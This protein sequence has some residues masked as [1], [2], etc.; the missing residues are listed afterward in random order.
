MSKADPQQ[1][2]VTGRFI[3]GALYQ[4][5]AQTN[6]DEKYS[7]C[8]VLDDGEAKKVEAAIQAAIDEKWNGKKP[9]GAT[10]WGVRVGDDP[11]FE[12]SYENEFIN[13]KSSADKKPSVLRRV[14]GKME[15]CEDVYAGAYVAVSV[16][17]YAYEGDTSK[18]IKPG[19]AL[20]LGGVMFRRDGERIGGGFSES[21]F[22]GFESEDLDADAFG[23][24][25][26]S[27]L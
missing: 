19:V 16:R 5:K 11:D 18:G 25:A 21:D 6:G 22:D 2:T 9:K 3:G 23:E 12:H 7:A 26:E 15:P 4:P 10:I 20:G 24:E 13:P 27:L 8:V 1:V 14:A 17:A